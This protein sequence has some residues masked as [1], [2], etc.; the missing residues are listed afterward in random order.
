MVESSSAK[1]KGSRLVSRILP[2]AIRLWLQTQLEHVEDLV[3][4]IEGRDRDIL[5][6]HIPGVLLSAQKAIY[7][8]IHLSQVA[9][10][11]TGIRINLGQVIRRRPLRLLT[12]FPLSGDLCL[13]TADL[14]QSLQAPLLGA[15]LYEFLKLIAKSQSGN[16]DALT[17]LMQRFPE[18]TVLDCYSPSV[19]ITIPI[20]T[21]RFTPRE[22]QTVP[23]IEL[24]TQ[25][26]VKDGNRLCLEDPRWLS[27][28]DIDSH[29]PLSALHSFEIDLGSE[30]TLTRCEL[31]A[32]QLSLTGTLRVLPEESPETEID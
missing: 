12:P 31:Q 1:S 21:L 22:G 23:P 2:P 19:S 20:L 29:P 11:A 13:T 26:T 28:P 30:V 17:A 32:D 16:M 9:V 14:N 4:Q 10:K 24:A 27:V 6:G 8:G 5:S 3:F 18:G 7:Q 15:G 25:L